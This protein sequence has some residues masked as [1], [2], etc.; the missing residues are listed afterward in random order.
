[1]E[2]D[3]FP[4]TDPLVTLRALAGEQQWRMSDRVIHVCE[5]LVAHVATTGE[6]LT[7]RRTS[8]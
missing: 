6:E 2:V 1:M 8:Q 3:A 7:V 4:M 5:R